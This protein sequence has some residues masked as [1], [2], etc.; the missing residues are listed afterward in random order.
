LPD[1]YILISLD[2]ISLYT[3]T[4]VDFALF[5]I[6]KNWN[7]IE[8]PID[9]E[10]FE[11]IFNF[12]TTNN[13]FSFQNQFYKQTFGFGMGNCLSPVCADIVVLNI[14]NIVLKN[15]NF[16]IPFF[17]RYVDDILLAIPR[18]KE[19]EVLQAF[20]SHH[21]RIQ[22]TLE[23]EHNRQIS[24]LDMQIIRNLDNLIKIDWYHK[25]TFSERYINFYSH[26]P[27]QHKINIIKNL[28]H[29]ALN[30]SDKQFHRKNL[31]YIHSTLRK[32]NY[33]S[34]L[35]KKILYIVNND[36]NNRISETKTSVIHY[37]KLTYIKQLSEKLKK[38]L[39]TEEIK[40]SFKNEN[41]IKKIFFTSIKDKTPLLWRSNVIYRIPCENC[42][43][44]YIG[45]T[46]RYLK[47]RLD[48]HKRSI[49]KPITNPKTALAEHSRS[50]NHNFD[51]DGVEVL[52]QQSYLNK[53]TIHEMCHI[54]MNDTVNFRTDVQNLNVCYNYILNKYK[55]M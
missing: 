5:L 51:F 3:N 45:Q 8:E 43:K 41:T 44:S 54:K 49:R 31:E 16:K 25:P 9:L 20:N 11:I 47:K 46:G 10:L 35:I 38:T 52:D 2:I 24:F 13:Y 34:S 12:L 18:G 23:I 53:R 37:A 4:P 36:T 28:K 6:Q 32:N 50:C 17:K 21:P 48:E 40:I 42:N 19:Q 1:N 27:L 30:L 7:L 33:P 55:C 26:N 29:R 39:E 22:F 15:F 14:Q